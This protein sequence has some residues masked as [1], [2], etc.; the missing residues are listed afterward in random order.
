MDLKIIYQ[1]TFY[2]VG[3][4]GLKGTSFADLQD[5]RKEDGEDGVFFS[6]DPMDRVFFSFVFFGF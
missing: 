1:S 4:G 2:E 6:L 3:I 5:Y